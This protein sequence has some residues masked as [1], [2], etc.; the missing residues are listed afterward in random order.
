MSDKMKPIRVAS[1]KEFERLLDHMAEEAHRASDHWHLL[2]GLVAVR[3]KYEV[4][5]YESRAFWGF[6][7]NAHHDATLFR[8]ARLYDQHDCSLSLK[9][10]LLTVKA[11]VEYFSDGARRARLK[12]NP[13]VEGLLSRKLNLST[14]G[15]DIRRVSQERDQLVHRLCKLRNEALSHVEPNPVRLATV[16][17][18][19]RLQQK[20]IQTL[21]NRACKI[22]NSYSLTYRASMLSAKVVGEDDYKHLLDLVRRGRDSVIAA[23]EEEVRRYMSNGKSLQRQKSVAE[24]P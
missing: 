14:L 11:S 9:R 19:P 20:E 22:L 5:M 7:L 10:F 21:L 6:T 3:K 15:G 24:V 18:Q 17:T 23:Q 2:K 16:S 4:E 12:E 1:E 13:F 8:L